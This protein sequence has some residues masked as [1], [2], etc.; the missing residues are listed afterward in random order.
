[1]AFSIFPRLQHLTYDTWILLKITSMASKSTATNINNAEKITRTKSSANF[2]SPD[3]NG[4]GYYLGNVLKA[5]NS[6]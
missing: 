1:M 2:L 4:Q 3:S 5:I 6:F